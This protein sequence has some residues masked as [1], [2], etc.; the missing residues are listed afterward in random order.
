MYKCQHATASSLAATQP[1]SHSKLKLQHVLMKTMKTRRIFKITRS[2]KIEV[3]LQIKMG[4]SR[5]HKVSPHKDPQTP[6]SA[7]VPKQPYGH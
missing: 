3:I 4:S 6:L 1:S 2:N 7:V 5:T